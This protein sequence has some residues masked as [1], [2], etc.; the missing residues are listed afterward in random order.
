MYSLSKDLWRRKAKDGQTCL[1]W[2]S[3][4]HFYRYTNQKLQCHRNWYTV[5]RGDAREVSPGANDPP[6]LLNI[7]MFLKEKE[8]VLYLSENILLER[9]H[10]NYFYCF[11]FSQPPLKKSWWRLWFGFY[12]NRF[13]LLSPC[14][15]NE[16]TEFLSYEHDKIVFVKCMIVMREALIIWK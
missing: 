3:V 9:S 14:N 8:S 1:K 12:T 5:C 2:T 13:I 16:K 4:K 10:S 11:P 15:K 7:L 6:P